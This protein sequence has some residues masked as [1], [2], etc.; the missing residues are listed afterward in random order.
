MGKSIKRRGDRALATAAAA[1]DQARATL[2]QRLEDVDL[3]AVRKQ[4]VRIAGSVQSDVERRIR[5]RRRGLS[6]WGVAGITGLVVLSAAAVGV[7]FVVS[8]RE[9]REAAGRRLSGA[10]ERY[11]EL[12]GGRTQAE[13]DLEARV[14]EA[15]AEGGASPDGLAVVVEGRTVYLRGAVADPAYVDGAAERVHGVRGVVAVV[16]LTTSAARE[17]ATPLS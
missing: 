2:A 8:D 17:Q 11:A 10:R 3:D 14:N 12:T 13:S 1:L 15:I 5:P 9:R 16:N 6:P 4:G 7:A